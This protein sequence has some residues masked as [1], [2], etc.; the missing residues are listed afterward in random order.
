MAGSLMSILQQ[1]LVPQPLQTTVPVKSTS[2]NPFSNNPFVNYNGH[3]YN[4]A[5]YAKNNPVRGGYFAGYYNGKQN[6]V[7][8]RL[9]IEV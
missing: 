4:S 5:T 2:S 7:G 3:T 8:R 1:V 9:F 6:I